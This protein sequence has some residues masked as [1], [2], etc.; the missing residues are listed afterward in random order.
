MTYYGKNRLFRDK[1]SVFEEVAERRGSRA[2]ER[3]SGAGCAFI[4]YNRDGYLWILSFANYVDFD[5]AT[6]A[7]PGERAAV[8]RGR[9]VPVMCGPRGLAG[10]KNILYQNRGDGTF[11]NVDHK[12]HIDRTRGSLRNGRCDIRLR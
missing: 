9:G 6:A 10:A 11:A 2:Q 8:L 12:A 3:P 7:K 1:G 4:D 5:L